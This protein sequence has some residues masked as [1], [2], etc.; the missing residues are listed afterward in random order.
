MKKHLLLVLLPIIFLLSACGPQNEWSSYTYS[1]FPQASSFLPFS[2]EYPTNWVL[3]QGNGR[4]AFASEPKILSNAPKNMESGQILGS[5]TTNINTSPEE[6]VDF[7]ASTHEEVILFKETVVLELN[8]R[9]AAYKEG[10]EAE[11]DGQIFIIAVDMGQNQRGLLVA[12][13][14][15]DELVTWKDTLMKIM[16][17]LR[18]N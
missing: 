13:M 8:G 3:E 4:I 17:S 7:Y 9:P 5:L 14:A 18:V 1:D 15:A 12:K 11:E 16:E 2:F 6:M 10:M